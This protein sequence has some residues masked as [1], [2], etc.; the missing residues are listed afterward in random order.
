MGTMPT[1]DDSARLFDGRYQLQGRLGAGGMATV[2]LAEDTSLHRKVAIKMLAER[3]AEDEQFVERFRRE[4]Q[5][6]AG[7]NHPNIVAIYDR[8]VAEGT[9]YIAMEYLDGPTLKDVIDER[10][11]LEPNCAIGFATQILAALRFAHNHGVVHRDIKPHNVVVSPDGR[12]KVTDFGIARAGASQ[13]TEVG[14]IVGT[15]QYLSPE[16]ARGEVVGPPS[17]LYSVGIV[18]YEMLTG[19]VPFEGDSAV[20]IAMKHLS[21]EPVPPSVYAPGTPPALEQVVLRALSKDAGDRY[22]TAEEMSADLDRARRGVALSPR[23]EQMTRVLAPARGPQQTRVQPPRDTRVWDREEPPPSRRPPPPPPP[24][25]PKRSR[26]PWVLLALLVLAAGAVAAVAL[27]GVIGGG[28]ATPTTTAPPPFVRVPNGLVGTDQFSATD[29]IER[30]G[31][32]ARR[33]NRASPQ[34]PGKVIAVSPPGGKRLRRGSTVTLIVSKGVTNKTVPTITDMTV[35]DATALLQQRGLVLG[36]RSEQNDLADAGTVIA[37]DPAAGAI[38]PVGSPV[39]VTVSKGPKDVLVPDLT[40]QDE[41]T[42]IANLAQA[43]LKEGHV[44]RVAS[45]DQPSGLVVSNDPPGGTQAP[46]GSA[47]NLLLSSGKPQVQVPQVYGEDADQ[48]AQDIQTAGLVPRPPSYVPTSDPAL[49]NTVRK[50]SPEPGK[51]ARA[52]SRVIISVWSYTAP[53]TDTTATDTTAT[54]TTPTDST[55]VTTL[56]TP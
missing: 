49:D 19:R 53:A 47:V 22:Q 32:K 11:G 15:A 25:R 42:A 2:Y 28:S 4:A 29:Q 9:Y 10:G 13:M 27:S 3:Y 54:D 39:N 5:S 1:G 55:P 20:A 37:Q 23:T 21:E 24:V 8:G 17:D 40:G 56:Q 6:A 34:D 30:S 35:Q 26:W 12:L 7:L 14:S 51:L 44:G 50:T 48:A 16:Q 38:A 33:V 18:L 46:E 43:G 31:L 36:D 41:Q 52:G 45:S